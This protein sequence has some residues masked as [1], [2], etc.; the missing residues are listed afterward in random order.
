M[1]KKSKFPVALIAILSCCLMASFISACDDGNTPHKHTYGA[2]NICSGCGDEWQY[3]EG[4]E[5][6]LNEDNQSY[7]V[8]WIG[9]A[10]GDIVIPYGYNGKFV[11]VIG[12]EAFAFCTSIE[13]VTIPNSVAYIDTVAFSNCTSLKS[14][15]IPDSVTHIGTFAF[16]GCTNLKNIVLLGSVTSIEKYT[17]V[18]TAYYNN[19][20]NW[21]NNVLYIGNH[22]V[23]AKENISG[24]YV[25]KAGTK[26]IAPFAFVDCVGLESITIPNSVISIGSG[27]FYDCTA[28]IIWEDSPQITQIHPGAFLGYNGTKITIPDS[29]T[30]IGDFAFHKCP[31]LTSITIPDNVTIIGSSAFSYCTSL[32]SIEIPASVTII[33]YNAFLNSGNLTSVILKNTIGWTADGTDILSS[34][35]EDPSIAAEY[36]TNTYCNNDW[37]RN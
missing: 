13:S 23:G 20:N 19:D 3:S 17:F 31:N 25:I 26:V 4:L 35:L 2:D 37:T 32:E 7:Y 5:Y 10:T 36:L 16:E 8:S 24:S 22:L 6:M 28:K 9:T 1:K 18:D 11:T 29:V 30:L 15:T 33:Y 14:I 21:E 12:M 34:D 27:A